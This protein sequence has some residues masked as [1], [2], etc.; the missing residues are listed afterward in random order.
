MSTVQPLTRASV[1]RRQ[2]VGLALGTLAL[3]AGVVA[4]LVW[5]PRPGDAG[6]TGP[7]S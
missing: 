6:W 2:H 7:G 4:L 3:L 5:L 1:V